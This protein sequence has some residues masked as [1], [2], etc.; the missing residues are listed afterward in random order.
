MICGAIVLHNPAKPI[1]IGLPCFFPAAHIIY[2]SINVG[3][4]MPAHA[5]YCQIFKDYDASSPFNS[6]SFSKGEG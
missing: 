2:F 5:N 1:F 6:L 3:V 4:T